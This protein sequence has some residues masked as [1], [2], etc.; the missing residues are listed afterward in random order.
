M[1]SQ[2]QQPI[3]VIED[4]DEDFETIERV[5]LQ[6]GL[7]RISRSTSGEH[8]LQWLRSQQASHGICMILLDLN[9][10]GL[11]GRETLRAIKTDEKL[12]PIPVVVFTTS[13]NPR[14]IE[15]CYRK[16]ANS[17]HLKPIDLYEFEA[18][19]RTIVDYWLHKNVTYH[20]GVDI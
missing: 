4:S 8:A 9:M 16:G 20:A 11:D 19:V 12:Q 2:Y 10:P 5:T 18:V 14:D 7:A 17:Y 13:S 15:A 3:L 1:I 6:T